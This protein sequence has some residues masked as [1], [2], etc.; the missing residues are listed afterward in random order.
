M[1]F[2]RLGDFLARYLGIGGA[3]GDSTNPL[4][5]RGP[6][7]LFD[8]DTDGHQIR[9]NKAAVGDTASFLFQTGFSGRAEFGI[10]GSDNFGLKVSTDGSAFTDVFTVSGTGSATFQQDTLFSGGV[11]IGGASPDVTNRLSVNTEAALFNNVSNSIRLTLNKAAVGDDAALTYQNGFSTRALLGL[12]ANDD[13]TLKVSP[14]GSAFNDAIIVDKDTGEVSMPNTPSPTAIAAGSTLG[15]QQSLLASAGQPALTVLVCPPTTSGKLQGVSLGDG[16]VVE[17]YASGADFNAGT[18]LYREFM[19]LGEPIVFTGLSFGAI[20]TATQGFYGFG[21][22]EGPNTSAANQGVMPMLSF[23][24]SFKETFLYAFRNS[25]GVNNDRGII[26]VANGPLT[27]TIKLTNGSG[28]VTRSQENIVLSPWEVTHLDTDGNGEYILSGTEN[29]MA[30]ILSRGGGTAQDGAIRDPANVASGVLAT[31]QA[32]DCRLVLPTASD[33]IGNP[34]SGFMSAPYANTAVKWYDRQGDEG[35]LGTGS[36]VSPG[37]P[38]DIDAATTSGGTANSQRDHNPA[39]YTRFRATGLVVAHSGADG[40]GGDA[41]QMASVPTLSQVVAQPLYLVD[42]GNGDET[43]VTIF[44]PYS[45]TAKIYEWNNGTSSLDLA[46]TLPITRDAGITISSKEDQLHPCAASLS[47]TAHTNNT[48][49][50]GALNMGVIIADVPIGVVVQSQDVSSQTVRS[51]G[52]ATATTIVSQ[53][54]ETASYGWTPET[55]KAE[56]TEGSDGILYKRIITAGGTETWEV[57]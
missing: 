27:N 19:S 4:S 44:S 43:G 12:L 29:M 17:V 35:D 41:V 5:V 38:Q 53:E 30:C 33:I 1:A 3:T 32:W 7:V 34:R 56:I 15:L 48:L 46:Y 26:F 10:I 14:D 22:V 40:Q 16:N 52:G 9:V 13:W 25:T 55:L 37:S 28:T 57:A 2:K 6:G 31:G 18:V 42:S 49:L 20:I 23:G 47:N 36:G 45:G 24:L 54:D 51:Q 11:G 21:E 8:G 39:G 50:V